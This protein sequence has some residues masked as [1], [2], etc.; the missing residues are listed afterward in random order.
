[1]TTF[2][3]VFISMKM[4]KLVILA[5]AA[6]LCF[7]LSAVAIK[8]IDDA[9]TVG[10]YIKDLRNGK[11]VADHQSALAMT[12]ASVMK[13]LTTATAM[14]I[15]GPGYRFETPVYLVGT[16]RGST[17]N[18]R[19]VIEASGDP[20]VDSRYFADRA[21]FTDSIVAL[22]S[23]N[24]IRQLR[25]DIVVDQSR[26][27]DVGP[28]SRWEIDDVAWDYGAPFYGFN[29]A[30][31]LVTLDLS[32]LETEPRLV[33]FNVTRGA[34]SGDFDLVRGIYSTDLRVDGKLGKRKSVETT[35]PDPV[36]L[37]KVKM[38]SA[39]RDAGVTYE[40][41]ATADGDTIDVYRHQ[42]PSVAE[43][44]RSLMHRSDNM[45][46]DAMLRAVSEKKTLAAAVGAELKLWDSLEVKLNP[47][48]IF[49]GS[50][51]VRVDAITP[52]ALGDVLVAMAGDSAYV[53]AFPLVG[54]DGTVKNFL[55]DTPLEGKMALK[56]GSMTAVRC[57]AGY[58]LDGEGKPTHAVVIMVNNSFLKPAELRKCLQ[59]YLLSIFA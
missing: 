41:L 28:S 10:I 12:P 21:G 6:A 1:M 52:R 18:G 29:F 15:L 19:V 11:I 48:R 36:A 47:V 57:Y 58:K 49:D 7:N 3:C 54:F 27:S 32:S 55:R 8:G 33:K 13:C 50:G 24:G 38:M 31:N 14:K 44:A 53:A 40:L 30:D 4:K 59:N 26:F 43:I 2:V 9:A 25:G 5:I 34:K 46:A 37:F 56:S 42:S 45:M 35:V 23:R 16:K 17:L 20:A 22:L 51:L 39:L